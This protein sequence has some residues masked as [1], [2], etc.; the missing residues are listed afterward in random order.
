MLES[1]LDEIPNLGEIRRQSLLEHFGSI[2][3]LKKASIEEIAAIP[4]IG[5]RTA[6]NIVRVLLESEIQ[7]SVDTA[8]GEILER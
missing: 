7:L 4:G 8:T 2:A 6:E 3:A 1:L 5:P